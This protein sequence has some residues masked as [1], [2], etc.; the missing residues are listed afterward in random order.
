MFGLFGKKKAAPVR[1][2][3]VLNARLQPLDRGEIEDA[4][5]TAMSEQGFGIRT[6]GGGTLLEANGEVSQ[7]DIEIEIDDFSDKAVDTVK[8]VLGAMLAPRGSHL[9]LP[10]QNNQR[11]AFGT[12]EG[13]ALY[14]NGTDL[15]DEVYR[16]CDSNHVYAECQRLLE[17]VGHVA[18]H[19]QGP[20]ETA[21]YM[22]GRN[23]EEMRQRV[24]SFLQAYPLCARCRIEQIA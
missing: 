24:G 6:V 23:F 18:S 9:L 13:L 7:C 17:G 15:P 19:W 11:I 1:V 21:L 20:T 4:F 5:D 3:A 22:Y 16:T 12:H 10:S 2:M 8:G 14:L